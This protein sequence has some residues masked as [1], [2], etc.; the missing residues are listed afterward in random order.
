MEGI[1]GK[2]VFTGVRILDGS[3]EE[4]FAGEVLVEGNRIRGIAKDGAQVD[5]DGAMVSRSRQ[6][7]SD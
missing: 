3:G 7:P 1:M 2:T 5:R 6:S 4:P